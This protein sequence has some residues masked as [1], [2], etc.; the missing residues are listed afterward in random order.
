MSEYDWKRYWDES[1]RQPGIYEVIAVFPL[2][3]VSPRGESLVT[4]VKACS[5][6]FKAMLHLPNGDFIKG[7]N[8][9]YNL[10]PKRKF[11]PW[12]A[13]EWGARVG[14]Q[15]IHKP[16]Q[17]K[18]AVSLV[19][20]QFVELLEVARE[21]LQIKVTPGTNCDHLEQLDGSPCGEFV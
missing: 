8:H 14:D 3:E 6:E 17:T 5:G 10:V 1:T 7:D 18:Y 13:K 16:S 20:P 19:S 11:R 2:P 15:F 12:T 4:V 21:L 9:P